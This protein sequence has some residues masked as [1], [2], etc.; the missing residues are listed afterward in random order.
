[1]FLVKLTI[2]HKKAAYLSIGDF[3][4]SL[5]LCICI[6]HLL[7]TELFLA[8][9]VVVSRKDGIEDDTEDSCKSKT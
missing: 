1:M 3:V 4:F 9:L 5:G 7:K 2:G 6:G 8:E